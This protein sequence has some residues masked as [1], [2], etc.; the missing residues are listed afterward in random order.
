V[1]VGRSVIFPGRIAERPRRVI[2]PEL[3]MN[4]R[5]PQPSAAGSLI[6]ELMRWLSPGTQMVG[7]PMRSV[8]RELEEIWPTRDH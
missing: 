7:A 1:A 6:R 8:D 5:R 2:E 3:D 4:R